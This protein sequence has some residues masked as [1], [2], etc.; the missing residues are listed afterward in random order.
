MKLFFVSIF[1]IF[2]L[3]LPEL[4]LFLFLLKLSFLCL[5]FLTIFLM[6]FLLVIFLL[7]Q[8]PLQVVNPVHILFFLGLK[9]LDP[10]AHPLFQGVDPSNHLLL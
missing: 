9:L 1:L 6:D 2:L 3:L 10:F 5:S 7:L 8:L 4:V